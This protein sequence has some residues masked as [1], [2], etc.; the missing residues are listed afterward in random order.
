MMTEFVENGL[1]Y[2]RFQILLAQ[3]KGEVLASEDDDPVWHCTEI[4]FP[5]A[6]VNTFV[7]PEHVPQLGG[8]VLLDDHNEIIDLGD[9]PLGKC[10]EGAVDQFLEFSPSHRRAAI[11]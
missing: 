5:P 3:A 7:D 10:L 4:V 9:N 1:S 11:K 8:R 2:L 6:E